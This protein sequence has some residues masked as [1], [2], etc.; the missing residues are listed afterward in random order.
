MIIDRPICSDGHVAL[1]GASTSPCVAASRPFNSCSDH[2]CLRYGL[3]RWVCRD[4]RSPG[5]RARPFGTVRDTSMGG[6]RLHADA[7]KYPSHRRR[8][9]GPLW[10]PGRLSDWHRDLHI[11]FCRLCAC[12]EHND[13]HRRPACAGDRRSAH[14]STKPCHH[15]G[16]LSKVGARAGDWRLGCGFRDYNRAWTAAS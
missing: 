1:T 16:L 8:G 4:D 5:H 7:R 9:R 11:G 13:A 15:N 10:A 3:Y 6:Q 14:D 12:A 2:P